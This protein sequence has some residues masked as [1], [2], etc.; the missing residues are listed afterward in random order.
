MTKIISA[1]LPYGGSW[2]FELDSADE[3][4]SRLKITENGEVY[5]PIFRF[6]S[7]FIIGHTATIDKYSQALKARLET[8]LNMKLISCKSHSRNQFR[9]TAHHFNDGAVCWVNYS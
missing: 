1:G 4:K 2:T 8:T 6:A 3:N 5:N 9:Q 7:R